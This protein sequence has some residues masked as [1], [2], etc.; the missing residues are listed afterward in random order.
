MAE[1]AKKIEKIQA[2]ID[3]YVALA[4][5]YMSP[6]DEMKMEELKGNIKL[7]LEAMKKDSQPQ[8]AVEFADNINNE[9]T[10]ITDEIFYPQKLQ[11][12]AQGNIVGITNVNQ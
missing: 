7:M 1:K 12:D 8:T 2:E 9:M 6:E 10:R 4:H 3:N 11:R 5:S